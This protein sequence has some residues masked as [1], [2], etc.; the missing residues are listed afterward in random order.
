MAA[1][2]LQLPP[3]PPRGSVV[4]VGSALSKTAA[5]MEAQGGRGERT[6]GEAGHVPSV[7]ARACSL[8]GARTRGCGFPLS[9][10]TSWLRCVTRGA[11]EN[12][13]AKWG[14]EQ[15]DAINSRMTV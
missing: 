3:P 2:R 12:K 13:R 9:A 8:R 4:S 11:G 15:T 1:T 10:T 6:E 7:G 5:G 14:A